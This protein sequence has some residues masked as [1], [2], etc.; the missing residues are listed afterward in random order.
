MQNHELQFANNQNFA[1]Y[2]QIEYKIGTAPG[3]CA[4]SRPGFWHYNILKLYYI[5]IK[6]VDFLNRFN[7]DSAGKIL[8]I[9]QIIDPILFNFLKKCIDKKILLQKSARPQE[10]FK[11]LI[12]LAYKII[13]TPLAICSTNRSLNIFKWHSS[14]IEV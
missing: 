10:I 5:H 4:K 9:C 14:C 1:N 2:D 12:I 6:H 7:G 3:L 13:L 8:P 11:P